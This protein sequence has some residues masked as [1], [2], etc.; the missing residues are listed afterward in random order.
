MWHY[1]HVFLLKIAL[2]TYICMCHYVQE[3][4][5]KCLHVNTD[6]CAGMCRY[7]FEKID[8]HTCTYRHPFLFSTF[9]IAIKLSTALGQEMQVL[10][11]P[12]DDANTSAVAAAATGPG[13]AD[14]GTSLVSPVK[15]AMR[16]D[17]VVPVAY[18]LGLPWARPHR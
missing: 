10:S 5:L 8:V 18:G 2:H 6:F 15:K 7:L 4:L 16:S 17:R 1:V 11:A 9:F 12:R 14:S 3:F 13:K